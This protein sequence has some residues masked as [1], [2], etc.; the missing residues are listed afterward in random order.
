VEIGRSGVDGQENAARAGVTAGRRMSRNGVEG[1]KRS[2]GT[3]SKPL[4]GRTAEQKERQQTQ[5]N[6][7]GN[8]TPLPLSSRFEVSITRSFFD[9]GPQKTS[10]PISGFTGL[11]TSYSTFACACLHSCPST[12]LSTHSSAFHLHSRA[13]NPPKRRIERK[14]TDRSI[15]LG[16]S[17]WIPSS[18]GSV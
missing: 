17:G 18:G 5:Q 10:G 12:P 14:D 9:D 1:E 2:N 13:R 3:V 7:D 6:G 4:V 8:G 15:R 16:W 11:C